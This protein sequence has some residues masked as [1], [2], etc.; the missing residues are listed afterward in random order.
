[1]A[2]VLLRKQRRCEKKSPWENLPHQRLGSHRGITTVD[3]MDAGQEKMF[4]G[5]YASE[6]SKENVADWE[7]GE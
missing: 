2:A 1:M 6:V 5:S 4:K 7:E 3:K